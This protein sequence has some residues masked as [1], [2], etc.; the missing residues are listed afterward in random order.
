MMQRRGAVHEQRETPQ[1]YI[2]QI[3]P[4]EKRENGVRQ[5]VIGAK[6]TLPRTTAQPESL[7]GRG[8]HRPK[9]Q[10]R[11]HILFQPQCVSWGLWG[12]VKMMSCFVVQLRWPW[13]EMEQDAPDIRQMR[14]CCSAGAERAAVWVILFV[15][16]LSRSTP[17]GLW[18]AKASGI[19]CYKLKKEL[20]VDYTN[21]PSHPLH[22]LKATLGIWLFPKVSIFLLLWLRTWLFLI[23]SVFSLT[24]WSFWMFTFFVALFLLRKGT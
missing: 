13:T 21:T 3:I 19:L 20:S 22:T 12:E 8:G 24:Y 9:N 17:S 1:E 11:K 15:G 14:N 7:K 4:T 23:I 2:P 6:Q 10:S 5:T 16:A 18:H